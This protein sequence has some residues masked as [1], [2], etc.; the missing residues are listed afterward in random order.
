[1]EV[2][3]FSYVHVWRTWNGWRKPARLGIEDQTLPG[4]KF[5]NRDPTRTYLPES[6]IHAST[7]PLQR[8]Q[9]TGHP[10]LERVGHPSSSRNRGLAVRAIRLQP[11]QEPDTFQVSPFLVPL[12][13]DI[14]TRKRLSRCLISK[15]QVCRSRHC[16][17]KTS[18][19]R[20]QSAI[21]IDNYASGRANY[22]IRWQ[23]L[24]SAAVSWPVRRIWVFSLGS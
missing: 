5:P 10:R 3:Q 18:P 15:V 14:S 20:R 7:R 6:L 9:G 2:E 24:S 23:G 8:T 4:S 22:R 13:N 21:L 1:M 19:N 12:W 17:G 11:D 16:G